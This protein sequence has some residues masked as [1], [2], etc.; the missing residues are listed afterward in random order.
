MNAAICSGCL[1]VFIGQIQQDTNAN[2]KPTAIQI[3]K[4]W[5]DLQKTVKSVQ[6]KS[7]FEFKYNNN[8]SGK[9]ANSESQGLDTYA[10]S[11][12]SG[13]V[14]VD[15]YKRSVG[16][17]G[18]RQVTKLA[19]V[20]N[21]KYRAELSLSGKNEMALTKIDMKNKDQLLDYEMR[22]VFPWTTIAGLYLPEMITSPNVVIGN[23]E[24]REDVDNRR[25][26]RVHFKAIPLLNSSKSIKV[27]Q[28]FENGFVDLLP[29]SSY[30]PIYCEWRS[31]NSRVQSDATGTNDYGI[32]IGSIPVLTGQIQDIKSKT[33]TSKGN[34]D[35]GS[36][37]KIDLME[38]NGHVDDQQFRLSYFGLPEPEGVNW[39]GGWPPIYYWSAVLT[40]T[41]LII[42]GAFI[43]R[44]RW[45]IDSN[46]MV[47]L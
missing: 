42:V 36:V 23:V 31:A 24:N 44:N 11:A 25:V 22:S 37:N 6:W 4:C 27:P 39:D 21:P 10:M 43:A 14:R 8:T 46:K 13:W 33:N 30:A 19:R 32:P 1:L 41:L 20:T 45:L 47:G 3:M 12:G 38:Y 28:D 15:E 5:D 17:D 26:I 7:R 40:T 29:G 16:N 34:F 18:K 9:N 35:V 2:E